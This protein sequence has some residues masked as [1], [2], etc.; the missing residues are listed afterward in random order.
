MVVVAVLAAALGWIGALQGLLMGIEPG[1]QAAGTL[2]PPRLPLPK[3][4]ADANRLLN[5]VW[6][7]PGLV[8]MCPANW[9]A[10]A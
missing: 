2:K 4:E 7:L 1:G 3:S 10:L 8:G 5:G 6:Q 9:V